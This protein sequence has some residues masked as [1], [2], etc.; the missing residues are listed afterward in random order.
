MSKS[1]MIETAAAI[2]AR[3]FDVKFKTLK[4]MSATFVD[5]FKTTKPA[6][7]MPTKAIKRPIPAGIA[8][9]IDCGT[10]LTMARRAP[11]RVRIKNRTPEHSTMSK[12]LAY[13]YPM[14]TQIV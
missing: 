6:F 9:R 3:P 13:E 11:T 12:P 2:M 1:E 4:E 7:C 14:P 5:S 8:I 10:A